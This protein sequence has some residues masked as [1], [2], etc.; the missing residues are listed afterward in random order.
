MSAS[1]L[2]AQYQ[3]TINDHD[4][5]IAVEKSLLSI[6]R[7]CEDPEEELAI[8]RADIRR[9]NDLRQ[10]CFQFTKDLEDLL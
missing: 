10:C 4:S 8:R 9:L 5:M 3:I 2:I 6:A 1:K 7:Q